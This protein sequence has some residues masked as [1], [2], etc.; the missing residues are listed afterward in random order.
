MQVKTYNVNRNL[1]GITQVIS[2]KDAVND[3]EKNV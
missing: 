1:Y 2:G 3:E